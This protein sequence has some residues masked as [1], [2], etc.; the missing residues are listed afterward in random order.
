MVTSAYDDLVTEAKIGTGATQVSAGNHNHDLAYAALVHTHTYGKIMSMTLAE[1]N[2][3][4]TNGTVQGSSGY[5]LVYLEDAPYTVVW[6]GLVWRWYHGTL[7]CTVPDFSTFTWLNQA[8]ATLSGNKLSQS[9][10]TDDELHVLHVAPGAANF[11][12]V[13]GYQVNVNALYGAGLMAGG[14]LC[15]YESSTGKVLSYIVAPTWGT[16]GCVRNA[17]NNVAGGP[18]SQ[19]GIVW[20]SLPQPWQSNGAVVWTKLVYDGTNIIAYGSW[21]QYPVPSKRWI[22]MDSVA[23]ASCFTTAPDRAGWC[24]R[25]SAHADMVLIHWSV[26]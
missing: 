3:E 25:G 15:M 11:T 17:Y 18:A 22:Q 7:L 21:D 6:D 14:G 9:G 8:E 26:S 12:I 5:T 19:V 13:A 2:S 10:S 1:F 20:Q 4:T 23:K 24:V 16:A